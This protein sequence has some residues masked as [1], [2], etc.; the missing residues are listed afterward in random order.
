[1][2]TKMSAQTLSLKTCEHCGYA[3]SLQDIIRVHTVSFPHKADEHMHIC[4]NCF[5]F[6]TFE[7]CRFAPD[8]ETLLSDEK[9][10]CCSDCSLSK[11]ARCGWNYAEEYADLQ[12]WRA[13]E[14]GLCDD[15]QDL[16]KCHYC[17]RITM[18]KSA[19]CQRCLKRV[20]WCCAG[21]VTTHGCGCTACAYTLL[22][23]VLTRAGSTAS[24]S[25]CTYFKR[26]RRLSRAFNRA[27][28][29]FFNV[30]GSNGAA[31]PIRSLILD[32]LESGAPLQ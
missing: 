24:C 4:D 29:S 26:T 14:R 21:N 20:C 30:H 16:L 31:G 13:S 18:R 19:H 12:E 32:Y 5:D 22:C 11:C 7:P 23:P 2:T 10:V 6:V 27:T 17:P 3:G 25:Q 9:M 28:S 1:L 15:C 8:C